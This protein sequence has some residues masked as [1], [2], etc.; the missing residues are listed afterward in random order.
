[1]KVHFIIFTLFLCSL[2]VFISAQVVGT[3]Y[4]IDNSTG[5]GTFSGRKTACLDVMKTG[6][7]GRGGLQERSGE[8]ASLGS[9]VFVPNGIVSNVRFTFSNEIGNAIESISGDNPGLNITTP[10]SA[11]LSYSPE[12]IGSYKTD[13]LKSVIYVT[14]NDNEN[15]S[16]T[17][18][19]LSWP[20]NIQDQGCCGAYT[21]AAH[22]QWATF[23]CH[24]L[25][26]NYNLNPFTYIV[27]NND[28]GTDGTLGALYQWGRNTDGHQFRNSVAISTQVS[29]DNI[30]SAG[31][32]FVKGYN[33]W[34]QGGGNNNRWGDGSQNADMPKGVN[35]PCPEGWKVPSQQQWS[36]IFGG[37]DGGMV[38]VSIAQNNTWTLTNKGFMVGDALFLPLGG[39]REYNDA[40]LNLSS[41]GQQYGHYWTSTTI[42]DIPILVVMSDNKTVWTKRDWSSFKAYGFSVRCIA[43]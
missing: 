15:N 13:G 35:D 8:D 22:T 25:G 27:G 4:I 32:N 3:P 41:G 42:S 43:E 24:N 40:S 12:A 17:D 21:D 11:T 31:V 39:W 23:M 37:G 29:V 7:N 6:G 36:S 16:G 20:V 9:I 19:T 18:H 38:S 30:S 33:D 28:N 10:V 26:T 14:Y 1:M 2:G 34:L 5:S